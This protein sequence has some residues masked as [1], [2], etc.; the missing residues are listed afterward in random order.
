MAPRARLALMLALLAAP[1][2]VWPQPTPEYAVKAVF[3][4]R[5]AR[6]VEW[7]AG[8]LG[9]EAEPF[10][11]AVLGED[12]F[13]GL[14]EQAY[15]QRRIRDRAVVV[16][17]PRSV[18]ELGRCHLL[19]VSSRSPRLLADALAYAR[20]RPTL[21][22]SEAPGAI[23]V[24]VHLNFYRDGENVRFEA[25]AE[26]LRSAGFAASYLLL[27]SARPAREEGR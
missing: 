15:A 12:P 13:E 25:N 10:V 11:I 9:A 6:F 18:A 24:G 26:A 22:V 19:F 7:P 14:L 21:L 8:A 5:F 16:R 3:L 2:A 17:H 4:E 23:E 20:N 27:Q 1:G